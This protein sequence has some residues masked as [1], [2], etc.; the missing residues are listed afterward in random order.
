MEK[1][2]C[3]LQKKPELSH[4]KAN[5]NLQ[6]KDPRASADVGTGYSGLGQIMNGNNILHKGKK[7]FC[8]DMCIVSC[9]EQLYI[10]ADLL[11]HFICCDG[12]GITGSRPLHRRRSLHGKGS[13]Q[14]R[15]QIHFR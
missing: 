3:N 1:T 8:K 2:E 15:S 5:C 10:I 6:K 4:G 7:R 14:E 11:V 9:K 13:V 12:P